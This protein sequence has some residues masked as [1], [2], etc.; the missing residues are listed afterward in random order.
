MTQPPP[1]PRRVAYCSWH[2]GLS[3]TALVVQINNDSAS[4][5]NGGLYYACAPCRQQHGLTPLGD[6]P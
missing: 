3:D 2:N 4:G 1:T 5:P 6:Q